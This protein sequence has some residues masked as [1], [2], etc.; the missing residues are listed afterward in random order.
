V[1]WPTSAR[2]PVRVDHLAQVRHRGVHGDQPVRP[3]G[4][5]AGGGHAD[6][7]ADQRGRLLGAG[8]QPG[9]IHPDQAVVADLLAGQQ[10]PD[11]VHALAQPGGAH[12]LARPRAAG[13]VLVAGL[14]GAEGRPEPAR[15]HR[16]EGADRLRDDRRVVP[17][18]GRVD[19]AERHAGGLQRRAQPGPGEAGFA[20]PGAP[21]GEVVGAHGGVEAGPLGVHHRLQQ[22]AWTDLLM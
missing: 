8:P 14:A 6:G 16:A 4:A 1:Q 5:P 17:L 21:R 11:H 18:T 9:P 20:L 19:H 15:V 10:G 7:G 12:V 2:V 13:D 22:G 3:F